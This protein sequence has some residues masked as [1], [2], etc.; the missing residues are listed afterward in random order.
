VFVEAADGVA[1]A[2]LK[3]AVG[4]VDRFYADHCDRILAN[5]EFTA[6]RVRRYYG[7]DSTV[8]PPPIELDRFHHAPAED[9]PYFVAI[10]RLDEM[11]RADVL[12]RAFRGL[13]ADLVLVGDGPLREACEQVPGVRV[14]DRLSDEELA[15][16]VAGAVGGIAFAEREHCGMTPKEFQAAGKPVVVP[17]EPNLRNHVLDDETGVVV[18]ATAAGVREGVARVREGEWD[19]DRIRG[20]A[21]EW[22]VERFREAVREVVDDVTSIEARD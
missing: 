17:D 11:K 2:V 8:L 14:R 4:V 9:P 13:E 12:A 15:A 22:S 6:D 21:E 16:L 10:G 18:P 5:S 7:R 20:A 3:T 19:P 1:D